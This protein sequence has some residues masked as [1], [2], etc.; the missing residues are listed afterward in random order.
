VELE[1]ATGRAPHWPI[2]A[3]LDALEDPEHRRC[4]LVAQ[5]EGEL[6]GFAVGVFHAGAGRTAE[7]ESVAVAVHAR[8]A[9]VGRALCN[10]VVEWCRA[11]GA[12]EVVLEVRVGSADAVALY[13]SLGFVPAGS[14][15]RYYSDP[16]EDALL[17]KLAIVPGASG[18][19]RI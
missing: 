7:L 2:S 3:Y 18:P 11:Q 17:M 15:P 10:A 5:R 6:V 14:R 9:G 16:E 13:A 12:A 4:V 1:R 19:G 8:R